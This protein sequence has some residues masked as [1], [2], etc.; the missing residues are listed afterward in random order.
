VAYDLQD[1]DYGMALADPILDLGTLGTY[2]ALRLHDR[3]I[4]RPKRL[5][6]C[7]DYPG[8]LSYCPTPT[9]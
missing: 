2:E 1:G 8:S 6:F 5:A 3:L 7:K 9:K 4:E